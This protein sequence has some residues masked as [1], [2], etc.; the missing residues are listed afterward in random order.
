MAGSYYFNRDV[1]LYR[2]LPYLNDRTFCCW[3]PPPQ[4][5]ADAGSI[6]VTIITQ[7]T[8]YLFFTALCVGIALIPF[9]VKWLSLDKTD[10]VAIAMWVHPGRVT[11]SNPRPIDHIWDLQL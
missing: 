9:L 5:T 2:S 11:E 10:A 1:H 8:L 7:V 6:I 4:V 3:Y